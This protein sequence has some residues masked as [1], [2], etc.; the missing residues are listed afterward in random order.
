MKAELLKCLKRGKRNKKQAVRVTGVLRVARLQHF[1]L[2]A[3]NRWP[4]SEMG[5]RKR[6]SRFCG[7]DAVKISDAIPCFLLMSLCF[8]LSVVDI[9]GPV[10]TVSINLESKRPG[11][12]L[13]FCF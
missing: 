6:L 7:G 1:K 9:R 2:P 12:S 11:L 4:E 3:V 8:W 10:S 5:G 13:H